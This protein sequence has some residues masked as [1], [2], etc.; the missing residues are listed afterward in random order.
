MIWKTFLFLESEPDKDLH[1]SYVSPF[2]MENQGS[3]SSS[4]NLIK[5]FNS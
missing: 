3:R 5:I 2:T 4:L 1:R